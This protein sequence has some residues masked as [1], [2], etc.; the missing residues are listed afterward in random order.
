[1]YNKCIINDNES[2]WF[3]HCTPGLNITVK[4]LCHSVFINQLVIG[5]YLFYAINVRS[6]MLG[7]VSFSSRNFVGGIIFDRKRVSYETCHP[8]TNLGGFLL[9][10]IK[11]RS[12]YLTSF[13]REKAFRFII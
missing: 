11:C 2:K 12:T 8:V 5:K 1:M 4:M 6:R 10:F 7:N 13:L 9:K 3:A